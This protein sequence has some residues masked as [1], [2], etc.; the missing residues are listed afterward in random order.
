MIFERIE[1]MATLSLFLV[2]L[3]GK[4][5]G[6][7]YF[8]TFEVLAFDPSSAELHARDRALQQG[9]SIVQCEDVEFQGAVSDNDSAPGVIKE[10]GKS[11][12]D[13]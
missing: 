5:A 11:F 12:F 7:S 3:E 13:E 9:L 4:E 1:P 2:M 6:N 8:I 10:Y